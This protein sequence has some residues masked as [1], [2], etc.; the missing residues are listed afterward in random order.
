ML[1]SNLT[2]KWVFTFTAKLSVFSP[3][4]E[5]V[6]NC[7]YS[8]SLYDDRGDNCKAWRRK[9]PL[10]SFSSDDTENSVD[11]NRKNKS[12]ITLAIPWGWESNIREWTKNVEAGN[13][14]RLRDI[15]NHTE[16][17]FGLSR[18]TLHCTALYCMTTQKLAA[19]RTYTNGK[20]NSLNALQPEHYDQYYLPM[21]LLLGREQNSCGPVQVWI[22]I[23]PSRTR[24]GFHH[25][26]WVIKHSKLNFHG[27]IVWRHDCSSQ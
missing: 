13:V 19:K 17:L 12:I 15:A 27:F 22:S 6:K 3:S 11:Q 1:P 7:E 18:T 25:L 2:Y 24:N 9:R 8:C 21:L 20:K 16:P 26:H 4:G 14:N 23:L 10:T 5:R